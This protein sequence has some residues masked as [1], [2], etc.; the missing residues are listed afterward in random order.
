MLFPMGQAYTYSLEF[1]GK[2][3][4]KMFRTINGTMLTSSTPETDHK[5]REATFPESLDMGIDHCIH[6]LQERQYPSIFLKELYDGYIPTG[7]LL[8]RLITSGIM[9]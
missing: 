3:P 1:R 4:R 6:M 8:I 5:V 2:M 9:Y 7:Q